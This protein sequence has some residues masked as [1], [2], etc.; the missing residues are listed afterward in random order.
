MRRTTLE[1]RIERLEQQV[2]RRSRFSAD[3]ICFPDNEW[4]AFA[5][6]F[7]RQ[8]ALKVECP[9]HGKRM[10]VQFRRLY[11][12]AWRRETIRLWP[13]IRSLQFQ[14]AWN[15]SFPPELWPADEVVVD[16]KIVLRLKDGTLL[17]TN[18][19]AITYR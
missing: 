6:E 16:G 3:C 9:L 17:P 1:S 11:L 8:I 14:K 13:T 2:N 7:E 18:E 12:P 10:I 15:A 5:T 4:P 19:P